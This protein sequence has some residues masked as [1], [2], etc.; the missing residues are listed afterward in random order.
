MKK[1]EIREDLKDFIVETGDYKKTV[2]ANSLEAAVKSAFTLWPPKNPA[3]L[4]RV[5]AKRPLNQKRGDG[6]WHYM[7]TN[8][9]LKKV[10]YKVSDPP[11]KWD[12]IKC[13]ECGS[14]NLKKFF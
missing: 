14:I 13:S 2:E 9:M 10:V 11:K 6:L 7:H 4:T 3:I 8:V 1:E 5:K 12:V